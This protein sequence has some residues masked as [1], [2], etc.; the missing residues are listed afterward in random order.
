MVNPIFTSFLFRMD[1]VV[2]T[3]V[4]VLLTACLT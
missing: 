4:R 1:K 2:C 3:G